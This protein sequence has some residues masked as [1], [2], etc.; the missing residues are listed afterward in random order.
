MVGRKIAVLRSRQG[1]AIPD[2]RFGDII[3]AAIPDPNDKNIKPRPVL[4]ISPND[5]VAIRHHLNVMAISSSN[6]PPVMPDC[7]FE[8]P[9]D[10]DGHVTTGLTMRC[11]VKCDW[12]VSIPK[13]N[14]IRKWGRAPGAIMKKVATY[15]ANL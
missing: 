15:L 2:Y 8:L 11:V 14:V 9:W 3:E 6:F 7:W 10:P 13:E 5:E 4:I 12:R 1:P